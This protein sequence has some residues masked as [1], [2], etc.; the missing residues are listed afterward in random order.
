MWSGAWQ[1]QQALPGVFLLL[2]Q[3]LLPLTPPQFLSKKQEKALQKAPSAA[4]P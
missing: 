1:F 2:A 4:N 3:R